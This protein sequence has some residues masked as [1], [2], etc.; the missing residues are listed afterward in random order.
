MKNW[1]GYTKNYSWV[2]QCPHCKQTFDCNCYVESLQKDSTGKRIQ[3]RGECPSCRV[4]LKFIPYR[5]SEYVKKVLRLFYYNDLKALEELRKTAI[6][7][8]DKKEIQ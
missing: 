6:Y 2:V 1:D 8:Y 4:W 7:N 5:D 3:I